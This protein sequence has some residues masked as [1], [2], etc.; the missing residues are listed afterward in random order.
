MSEVRQLSPALVPLEQH[1]QIGAIVFPQLD[2]MDLTGPYA[3]LSRLPNSSFQL[4][5]KSTQLVRD[6]HGLAL[7]PDA[8]FADTKPIDLLVIP[9]GAGQESLMED[10]VVLS[11]VSQ[12]ARRAKC[13]F[14]ICTG[15]LVLGAAG[16]LMGRTAT[17]YWPTFP[18]LK[19]FGAVPTN[20]RVVIDGNYVTTAGLTAG[21]DGALR[22][23]AMLRGVR[24]GRRL[25]DSWSLVQRRANFGQELRHLIQRIVGSIGHRQRFNRQ[26]SAVAGVAQDARQAIQIGSHLAVFSERAFFHLK[27]H[28]VRNGL[29]NIFIRIVG[30]ERAGVDDYAEPIGVHQLDNFENLI[31]GLQHVAVVLD[32]DKHAEFLAV[33]DALLQ[34]G[35][36]PLGHGVPFVVGRNRAGEYAQ[37]RAPSLAA[38]SIQFFTNVTSAARLIGSGE[39]KLFRT[40]V[41]LMSM[42]SSNARCLKLLMYSSSGTFG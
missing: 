29:R 22:V 36:H 25:C 42:P 39:A 13:V 30:H 7:L 28:G 1:V 31:G 3:V 16:L 32:T 14:S 19:Y 8:T 23:A 9:G 15:A 18:S 33:F 35:G 40:P 38:T 17:S 41:P 21:I 5:W 4:L 34:I 2:Q 20:Q 27:I 12:Q 24:A 26:I 10:E 37:H 11:F 6:M